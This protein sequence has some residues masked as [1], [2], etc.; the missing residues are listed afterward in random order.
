MQTYIIQ[1]FEGSY[2][3]NEIEVLGSLTESQIFTGV[4]EELNHQYNYRPTDRDLW[5]KVM[6]KERA[7]L[8]RVT[9]LNKGLGVIRQVSNWDNEF[10]FMPLEEYSFI[11]VLNLTKER[12]GK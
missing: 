6:T 4:L 1:L 12:V 2:M 9:R 3:Y 5:A 10:R 8:Y 11:R 7:E